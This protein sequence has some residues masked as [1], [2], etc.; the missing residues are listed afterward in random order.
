MRIVFRGKTRIVVLTGNKAIKIS[1][2]RVFRLLVRT[3]TFP[4]MSKNN[5][6]R[7]YARYGTP[8]WRGALKYF[9]AGVYANW[10]EFEY[11]QTTSDPRVIPTRKSYL[12]GWIV[13]QDRGT[14]VS[15]DELAK[16]NPFK[17]LSVDSNFLEKDQPWQFCYLNGK[18]LL[19]DYGRKETREALQQTLKSCSTIKT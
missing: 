10:N 14:S 12:G 17:G 13:I 18:I 11:Y 8:F 19:A 2:V 9:V 5:H 1:R 4:L 6:R 3:I 16:Q 15:K 7:F